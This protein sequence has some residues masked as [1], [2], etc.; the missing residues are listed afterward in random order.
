MNDKQSQLIR[1]YESLSATLQKIA[2]VSAVM[3]AGRVRTGLIAFAA[4][5]GVTDDQ[6]LIPKYNDLRDEL[7]NAIDDGV[8]RYLNSS[9]TGAIEL[10]PSL[11]DFAFRQAFRSGLAKSVIDELEKKKSKYAYHLSHK[12]EMTVIGEMRMMFYSGDVS[13]WKK[14]SAR[15]EFEPTVLSPHCNEVFQ[16]L[17]PE[18]Q[19]EHLQSAACRCAGLAETLDGNLLKAFAAA[20]ESCGP[21]SDELIVAAIDLFA[22]RGD[23][24]ALTKLA[25]AL[26]RQNE[27]RSEIGGCI[28]FLQGDFVTARSHFEEAVKEF[29]KR[30]KKRSVE[31]RHV[32]GI[33]YGLLLLQENSPQSQK[34]LK[35]LCKVIS[36]WE[37]F[38]RTLSFPLEE[39]LQNQLSP[40]SNRQRT[41]TIDDVPPIY[42]WCAG[43]MWCWVFV[44]SDFPFKQQDFSKVSM[45]YRKAGVDWLAAEMDAILAKATP[46]KSQSSALRKRSDQTHKRLG[47]VSL[48]DLMEPPAAWDAGLMALENLCGNE[49]E[50]PTAALADASKDERMIWEAEYAH[51]GPWIFLAPFVQKL[52]K[53]GWSKGR[54]VGLGRLYEQWQT[55]TFGFLTEQD[56]EIC[57][58]LKQRKETNYYGYGEIVHDWN[59]QRLTKAVIGHP[60]IFFSGNRDQPVEISESRPMLSIIRKSKKIKLTISP[61][62]VGDSQR[63]EKIGSHRLSVTQFSAKQKEM[64][65]LVAQLPPIPESQ[66]ERIAKLS[67]S[68]ASIIGVQSDIEGAS[69]SAGEAVAADSS[70]VVQLTTCGDGLRAE[71]FVHPLG[72]KGPVC[73]PGSGAASVFASIDGQP[74]TTTRDL[75]T[76]KKHLRKLLAS[77]PL[78]D[79]RAIDNDQTEWLFPDSEDAME[80][81]VELHELAQLEK[82]TVLWPRGKTHDVAGSVSSSNFQVSVKRD[83]DWFAA[84][85]KLTVDDELTLDMMK[86]IELVSASPTRFLKLDDGRFLALS[87][88]LRQRLADIAAFGNATKN[89]LR[90][91][92][93]RAMHVNESLEDT[94]LKVDKHWKQHLGR[95][96]EAAKIDT[97]PPSNLQTELRD[98]QLDGFAWLKRLSHWNTGACLADDM[99]L[100]KTIQALALLIERASQGPALVIAPA[101]V[102]FNWENETHKFAPS[103]TPKLFRNFD[104]KTFFDDLAPGDL[105]IAS[106]G[107]LQS[108]SEDFANVQWSTVLLDEAQAIKN[109][110]TKRSHAAMQLQS[111]FKVILTGT[112]LENHL[113]ELWNL[114]RFIAPGLLGSHEDFRKRFAIPI[115]RDQCRQSRN[116][117]RKLIQPFLLRRTKT[118][119]LAELPSRTETVL[120]VEMSPEE[121]ALYEAIRLN[122]LG[123]I[124]NASN[125]TSKRGEKHL[126]VLAE[127]TRLRLACCHP[128]LVGGEGIEG[129][130]LDLFRQKV[131]EIVDGKHK[132]LVFSQFVKHLS[133]LSDELEQMGLSYQYLD[134]STPVKKRKQ[135]VESFQAGEGDVF[136]ISLKAGGTGLNLTAADYVIH[137]DP[138]WNPAVED[139]ATDRAHRIGQTRPV[140]VYRLVTRGTIEEKIVEL[141][142]TKR[143]LADSLLAGT[144]TAAKL[145]TEDLINLLRENSFATASC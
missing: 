137:M 32:S 142:H 130:K 72:P 143:D 89:K 135:I 82:V 122:A 53:K 99:G 75:K 107:L 52:G 78:L 36:N 70:V 69:I 30:T 106:Y 108:N 46:V 7:N 145:T 80:L 31:I 15:Y 68:V 62:S 43:L 13:G 42:F 115:E 111:D 33:F 45:F 125:E 95:I 25:A 96:E 17:V 14:H 87:H 39:A 83:R 133:I 1:K 123:N 101:S 54:K 56:Q 121:V 16:R 92:P 51:G 27:V 140:N 139:Q 22:V 79:S 74:V 144:D 77:C 9:Q 86:L 88:E 132:V 116:R 138:W 118:E 66:V 10:A 117:L 124:E 23:I 63:V 26:K 84:T 35:Q 57:R 120:E 5:C 93:I 19:H 6:G 20:F 94:K 110:D 136:L 67:Q 127:L 61:E 98:Y 126:R 58:C 21:L 11:S 64:A 73:R 105:A 60:L 129:S 112:P 103:L 49:S 38:Y 34:V 102:G 29:R 141:H 2:Q 76:E 44:E 47:A 85:G 18:F 55:S 128:S 24:A 59:M 104:R 97:Q 71:L 65:S 8:F 131:R 28:A 40:I 48:V 37:N 109:M 119:V 41:H 114:I 113:G 134:G 81:V 100:G 50:N 90:I 4:D 12:D 91:P 3:I